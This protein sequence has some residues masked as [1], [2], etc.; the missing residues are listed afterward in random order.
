MFAGFVLH[1]ADGFVESVND[2][3]AGSGTENLANVDWVVVDG[4][5]DGSNDVGGY[6]EGCTLGIEAKG[7]DEPSAPVWTELI[8]DGV[9]AENLEL[10]GVGI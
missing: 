6:G 2:E 4:E 9:S 7:E 10:S 8:E 5:R 1:R 3:V